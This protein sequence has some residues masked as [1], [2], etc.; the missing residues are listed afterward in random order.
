MKYPP[1][2]FTAVLGPL[3]DGP[4][5]SKISE[6]SHEERKLQKQHYYVAGP[7]DRVFCHLCDNSQDEA[8][9]GFCNNPDREVF[10]IFCGDKGHMLETCRERICKYCKQVDHHRSNNC[11]IARADSCKECGRVNHKE[12][13]C[14]PKNPFCLFCERT[15]HLE[16][17]CVKLHFG[18]PDEDEI[19][20]E[21]KR[22]KSEYIIF[23]G[24]CTSTEHFYDDC[25][26]LP[27]RLRPSKPTA[28]SAKYHNRW[29]KEP[30]LVPLRNDPPR[31]LT[32]IRSARK[33]YA[34]QGSY[35]EKPSRNPRQI[36]APPKHRKGMRFA[37]KR[38]HSPSPAPPMHNEHNHAHRGPTGDQGASETRR[39]QPYTTGRKARS[40]QRRNIDFIP[41]QHVANNSHD[42]SDHTHRDN[43]LRP[44]YNDPNG[45][46]FT[47]TSGFRRSGNGNA[48]QYRGRG[49]GRNNRP[50]GPAQRSSR[51]MPYRG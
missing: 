34:T 29:L 21:R 49:R 28:M 37:N 39:R 14:D 38:L 7:Q 51:G 4:V 5:R 6:L 31:S 16:A 3:T 8:T 22:D 35:A 44:S 40:P 2:P 17:D 10:C 18:W 25:P 23:C 15:T 20:E 46:H 24:Y 32:E 36:Q 48:N 47:G 33:M 26:D 41:A 42:N 12:S 30:L 19:P 27:G 43:D 11:H 1:G 13:E 9:C 50:R 45:R